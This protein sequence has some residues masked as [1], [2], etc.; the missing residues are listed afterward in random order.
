MVKSFSKK[1]FLPG[2]SRSFTG[3]NISF[4]FIFHSLLFLE[5]KETKLVEITNTNDGF[6]S[7]FRKA[8][9]L[10]IRKSRYIA[11][12]I[13]TRGKAGDGRN[14]I[15]TT[16]TVTT[17]TSCRYLISRRILGIL[18]EHFFESDVA[19]R[20]FSFLFVDRGGK[21]KFERLSANRIE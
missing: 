10:I 1:R 15:S 12:S 9:G 8:S 4:Y 18:C 19:S 21:I 5:E 14:A 13:V 20:I 3:L 17:I 7:L 2:D 16:T 11:P 6:R